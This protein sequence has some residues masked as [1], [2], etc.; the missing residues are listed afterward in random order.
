MQKIFTPEE[1][2]ALQKE[3]V[4]KVLVEDIGKLIKSE[5]SLFAFILLAQGVEVLGGFVDNKPMKAPGQSAKRFSKSLNLFMGKRYRAIN[6]NH[7]FYYS[8]RN[9]LTHSFI[10]SRD[11]I[12]TTKAKSPEG[13]AHLGKYDG[14]LV[15]VLEDLY[16]DFKRGCNMLFMLLDSGKIKPTMVGDSNPFL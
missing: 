16:C 9:Q 11:L 10:P 14:R 6:L 13:T 3:F 8:Y 7:K 2:I 12:L 4:T 1:K 15:L 5:Q